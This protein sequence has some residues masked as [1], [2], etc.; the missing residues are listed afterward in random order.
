MKNHRTKDVSQKQVKD[1]WLAKRNRGRKR[2]RAQALIENTLILIRVSL[3][4]SEFD[5]FPLTSFFL[6]NICPHTPIRACTASYNRVCRFSLHTL[7]GLLTEEVREG[8]L[9]CL[10]PGNSPSPSCSK[11]WPDSWPPYPLSPRCS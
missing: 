2:H 3:S 8:K 4:A 11:L 6:Y 9:H 10:D 5:N 7:I 1:L